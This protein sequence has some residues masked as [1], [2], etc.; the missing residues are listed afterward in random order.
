MKLLFKFTDGIVYEMEDGDPNTMKGDFL[1]TILK[2]R[3]K[4]GTININNGTLFKQWKD[5]RS[6]EIVFTDDMN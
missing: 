4:G 6:V 2:A 3:E 5:L 1:R